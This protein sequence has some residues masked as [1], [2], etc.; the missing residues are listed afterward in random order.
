M[1]M[2]IFFESHRITDGGGNVSTDIHSIKK[3]N[4]SES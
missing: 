4:R 3:K 1:E 2:I